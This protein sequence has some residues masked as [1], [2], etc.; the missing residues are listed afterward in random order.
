MNAV[1]LICGASIL[2]LAVPLACG[3]D[4]N[5]T[6]NGTTTTTSGST[7]GAGTTTTTS[8]MTDTTTTSSGG[9]MI[10]CNAEYTNVTEGDCDLLQQDCDTGLFCS[11]N[12]DGTKTVCL[13]NGSGVKG[14][15]VP[16]EANTECKSG[17]YCVDKLCSPVC[18]K[19][20]NEPCE[21]GNC[22]VTLNL[23]QGSSW[24]S[25]CSYLTS[26]QLFKGEC[27][28]DTY[29]HI[30]DA[31]EGLAVCDKA[32][33]NLVD[34][35]EPCQFRNDCKESAYCDEVDDM[36]K[37]GT[38]R[39]LCDATDWETLQPEKGGCLPNRKCVAAQSDGFP[40]LGICRPS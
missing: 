3:S 18:C 40:N 23:N 27:P 10:S 7:G 26:C 13:P 2:A 37:K 8:N 39:H 1:R 5:G 24:V 15:G 30:A 9:G 12:T 34:E 16:C 14:A 21:G 35:G 25:V 36:T 33:P 19:D 11:V 28:A 31:D 6:T 20:N 17:M 22:D 32:S 29:C 4:G 38:C